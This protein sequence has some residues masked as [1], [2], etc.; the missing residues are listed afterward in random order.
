MTKAVNE[1]KI[2]NPFVVK[3]RELLEHRAFWLYL[4][5]D[6]ACKK[7]YILLYLAVGQLKGVVYFKVMI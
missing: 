6:E 3:I 2:K 1:A 7:A 4:L 5:T